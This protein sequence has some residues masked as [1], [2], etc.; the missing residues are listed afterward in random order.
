VNVQ[1][2]KRM[3]A[4]RTAMVLD[5]SFWGG[6]ALRLKLVESADK[7][8]AW[9]DGVH[10][11]YNPDFVLS[12]TKV[13]LVA[14]WAHEVA[15]CILGHPWRRCGREPRKWNV[16]A[17]LAIN[18]MLRRAGFVLPQGALFPEQFKLPEGK[19]AEWY[20]DRLP[21]NTKDQGTPKLG[22][23][24]DAPAA[25]EEEEAAGGKE[26]EGQ[27]SGTGGF[28]PPTEEDWKEAAAQMAD[29]ARGMGNLPAG[30]DRAL[31]SALKPRVD[32]RSAL[33][34]FAQEQA[35]VDYTWQRPNRRYLA[36]GLYL[37]SLGGEELGVLAVGVD[38]SGSIDEVLLD[39][40]AAEVKE[41]VNEMQPREV[42][43]W[44]CDT[45]IARKEVF[46]RGDPVEMHAEG[47]GGTDFR[48]VFAEL[49]KMEEPPVAL[50]YLTDLAGRFPE[51]APE[52]PT[53]WVT[54]RDDEW[55]QR[56]AE[57]VPFGE[58]VVAGG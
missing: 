11:G 31:K 4:H 28:T 40:F 34:R 37:P 39:Q 15:H 8:T 3:V 13:E 53:L 17:D 48:P 54:A 52:V 10:I 55:T 19:S 51:T 47:G 5:L 44:Y 29:V 36:S 38:T 57:H 16:A 46:Y 2:R 41:L 45:K 9:T 49:D 58:V 24:T 50:L 21:A 23:V 18:D 25:G 35:R 26:G 1:A 56:Y 20:Y 27:E 30:M 33:R 14:L 42:H 7:P 6:L 32:W 43:V 12:L 22:E